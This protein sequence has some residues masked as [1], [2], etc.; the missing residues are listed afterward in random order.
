MYRVQSSQ[1]IKE[2][3]V[4]FGV[5]RHSFLIVLSLLAV[6]LAWIAAGYLHTR[7]VHQTDGTSFHKESRIFYCD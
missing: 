3:L 1:K 4:V 6:P 7:S 2:Q 5:T